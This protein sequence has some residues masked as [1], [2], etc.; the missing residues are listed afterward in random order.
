MVVCLT[1]TVHFNIRLAYPQASE[2]GLGMHAQASKSPSVFPAVPSHAVILTDSKVAA[3]FLQPG[4]L[5]CVGPEGR[6]EPPENDG[7]IDVRC[8]A[9]T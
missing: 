1:K 9:M 3:R 6:R 4:T 7:S 2:Y 8:C 5:S